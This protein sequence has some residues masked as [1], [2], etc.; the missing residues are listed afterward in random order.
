[1]NEFSGLAAALIGSFL[2][3]T[4]SAGTRFVV[5]VIDP[6]AVV[7]LRY[8]IG[9]LFLAP[10]AAASL[11]KLD[12]H[13]AASI[14]ILGVIFFALYPYLF[15]L[16]FAHTTAAR[17]ALVLST[18]PLMTMIIAVLLR[19]ER[20]SSQRLIGIVLAMAGLAYA[21]S[22]KL[23]SAAPDARKGDLIMIAA[24]FVQAVC[25][26]LSRPYIR[27]L[28]ALSFTSLALCI[29]AAVLFGCSLLTNVFHP[30]PELSVTAWMIMIYLGVIGCA[31]LWV[32]WSVG[33]R[34]ASPSL[35]AMT[36][37]VNAL[38]ASFLGAIFL[39]EP[40]GR[41]FFVGLIAVFSGIAVATNAFSRRSGARAPAPP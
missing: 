37:T 19:Q 22:P 1:M 9:A 8:G 17:G 34:L 29:G 13:D 10:F 40:V 21:L 32:L 38:T 11:R 41:E 35:V 28:G 5:G 16:S 7:T 27:R 2:G 20:F 3:G 15:S 18:M 25:N 6:L 31:F 12:S 33:I 14:S 36:V 23:A 30:L 24:T 39:S 4:A 26:V